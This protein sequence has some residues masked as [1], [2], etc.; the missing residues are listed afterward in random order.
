MVPARSG[1]AKTLFLACGQHLLIAP[2]RGGERLNKPSGLSLC[3]GT[4]LI[5]RVPPLLSHVNIITYQRPHLQT[6]SRGELG[7]PRMNLVVGWLGGLNI[8]SITLSYTVVD[9][10][11]A[12]CPWHNKGCVYLTHHHRCHWLGMYFTYGVMEENAKWRGDFA[13]HWWRVIILIKKGTRE[14]GHDFRRAGRN[15]AS[16]YPQGRRR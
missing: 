3:K 13:L 9:A 5:T 8:Q 11:G 15:A 16:L 6:P 2:S 14:E 1:L 12:L 4:H 7:L 10:H